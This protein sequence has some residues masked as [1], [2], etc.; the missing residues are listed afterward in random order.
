MLV[1]TTITG[2]TAIAGPSVL[3]GFHSMDPNFYGNPLIP[4]DDETENMT[5]GDRENQNDTVQ[6][7]NETISQQ[8]LDA[9][10]YYGDLNQKKFG[11]PETWIHCGEG[12]RSAMWFNPNHNTYPYC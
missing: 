3:S 8:E 12:T 10:W 11:T 4:I 9:G 5:Y 6:F 1:I 7:I 2:I